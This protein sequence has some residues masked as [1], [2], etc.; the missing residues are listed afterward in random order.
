MALADAVRGGRRRPTETVAEALALA[1]DRSG[2]G[3]LWKLAPKRAWTEA[4]ALEAKL[5][6]AP[7]RWPLAGVPFVVKD[8]FDFAG[9][10]TTG[11]LPGPHP[12][13]AYSASAVRALERAGAI[14]IGK[15]AMDPLAWSTHG[16]AAGFPPCRNP[17]TPELSPGGSSAGSAV[18]VA[19][20]I[21]GLGLGSDTAGS[22]RIPAAY[23]GVVGLKLPPDG[24]LLEGCLPVASSFD[25]A[26]LLAGSVRAC[27]AAAAVLTGAPQPPRDPGAVGVLSDLF[28]AADPA[29]IKTL[30]GVLAKLK[31]AGLRL[32]SVSLDWRAPGFGLLLAVEFATAWGARADAAP[33][34]FPSPILSAIER[35]R[36][37]PAARYRAARDELGRAR[38]KLEHRLGG[39]G[40][41]LSP[42]VPTAV[43]SVQDENVATSTRFTRIFSALGWPAISVPAGHDPAGRPVGIHV[44]G[45]GPLAPILAT[46]ALVELVSDR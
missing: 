15:T 25:S 5:T 46:A 10:P 3:A 27:A 9:L 30:D 19:A 40:A 16:Q 42:T 17:V 43:P 21:V 24:R 37:V 7:G 2:L 36:E 14:A 32:E 11:G 45:A 28:E 35:A 13:A 34:R 20:G 33:E 31:A 26:G 18:A 44:T 23:C 1:R 4:V 41:L 22:V 38:R 8:N 29:V 12:A 39:Y 6:R